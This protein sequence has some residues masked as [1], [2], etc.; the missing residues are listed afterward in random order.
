M[1]TGSQFFSGIK[2]SLCLVV[3]LFPMATN[4][5][6]SGYGTSA[7]AGEQIVY[8]QLRGPWFLQCRQM[9]GSTICQARF[10]VTQRAAGYLDPIFRFDMVITPEATPTAKTPF[11]YQV[12]FEAMP[13]PDW[14]DGLIRIGTWEMPLKKACKVGVC[15]LSEKNAARLIGKMRAGASRSDIRFRDG[16]IKRHLDIPLYGFESMLETLEQQSIALNQQ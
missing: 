9:T 8:Q 7:S 14:S 3:M 13:E 1:Q 5:Q 4:A 12:T 15:E 11:R 16:V 2:R 10:T 6:N